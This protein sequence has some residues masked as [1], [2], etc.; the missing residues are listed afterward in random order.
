MALLY[1]ASIFCD[2][3]SWIP[4]LTALWYATPL[5]IPLHAG[6]LEVIATYVAEVEKVWWAAPRFLGHLCR[7]K[8]S[9][10]LLLSKRSFQ[11]EF[12]SFLSL[13]LFLLCVISAKMPRLRKPSGEGCLALA[14]GEAI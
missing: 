13:Q 8:F 5:M 1:L 2:T 14:A 3:Y 10:S 6:C 11:N 4:F 9:L 12:L 7:G